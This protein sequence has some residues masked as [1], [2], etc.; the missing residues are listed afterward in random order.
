MPT[1]D[2]FAYPLTP[3]TPTHAPAGYADSTSYKPWLRDD[4]AFRCAYCLTR[5]RWNASPTGHASFG[6]DHV[7]A[8]SVAPNLITQYYNLMYACNP[9]NSAKRNQRIGIDPRTDAMAR[10]LSVDAEGIV[11]A[12]ALHAKLM[13]EVFDLNEPGRISLRLE[14]LV[15]L[16]SK[17]THP[18]DDDIDHIIRRTFG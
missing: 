2:P 9:C 4:F 13:I 7:E 16:R 12:L 5:E 6:A 3:H 17:K 10:L 14:K 8:Q 11:H 18:D 15:I 1:P